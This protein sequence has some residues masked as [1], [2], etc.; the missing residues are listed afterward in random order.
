MLILIKQ[1]T[2]TNGTFTLGIVTLVFCTKLAPEQW[3]TENGVS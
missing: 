2:K 3:R 1:L